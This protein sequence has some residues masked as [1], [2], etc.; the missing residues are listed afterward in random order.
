MI[1]AIVGTLFLFAGAFVYTY[2]KSSISSRIR[3]SVLQLLDHYLPK[4]I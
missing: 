1:R 2:N 3:V 4:V